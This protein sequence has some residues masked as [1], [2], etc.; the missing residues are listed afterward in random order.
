MNIPQSNAFALCAIAVITATAWVSPSFIQKSGK[1]ITLGS[2]G[3][4][5]VKIETQDGEVVF[6]M[7]SKY[8]SSFNLKLGPEFSLEI[9]KANQGGTVSINSS[10]DG[11]VLV[12]VTGESAKSGKRKVEFGVNPRTA[13]VMFTNKNGNMVSYIGGGNSETGAMLVLDD[14][15]RKVV[16]AGGE[17]GGRGGMLEVRGVMGKELIAMSANK[18]GYGGIALVGP[19]GK[20]AAHILSGKHSVEIAL[21]DTKGK[22]A[23]NLR[24]VD[25]KRAVM[26][27]IE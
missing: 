9:C 27:I 12:D 16:Y 21:F 6:R 18:S 10:D 19:S 26:S 24:K 13:A 3:Q 7:D 17:A 5:F 20:K 8:G 22:L 4:G 14:Q 11:R 23:A 1:Q 15:N 2:K 25:G